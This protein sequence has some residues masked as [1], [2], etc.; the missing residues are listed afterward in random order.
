[1]FIKA[2]SH[3]WLVDAREQCSKKLD[4]MF[5]GEAENLGDKRALGALVQVQ[6]E[7]RFGAVGG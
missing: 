2:S 4:Q 7:A 5:V 1:L 6:L 3:T